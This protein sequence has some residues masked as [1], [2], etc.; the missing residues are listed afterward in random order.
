M[1]LSGL[2]IAVITVQWFTSDTLEKNPIMQKLNLMSISL[3]KTPKI[4]PRC[5]TAECT[6]FQQRLAE[7]PPGQIRAAIH[8]LVQPT[9]IKKLTT[10]LQSLDRYFNDRFHYPV[11][12]FHEEDFTSE[13]EQQV[14]NATN[15]DLYF[16]SVTFTLPDFIKTPVPEMKYS[17]G[18]RHMCRFQS[19]LVYEQPIVDNL[20]FEWRLDDD[21]VLISEIK[22]DIFKFMAVHDIIYGYLTRARDPHK[23]VTNLWRNA[24]FYIEKQNITTEF[25]NKWPDSSG[26]VNN[27]ELSAMKLWRSKRYQEYINYIDRA[28]GIYYHR[29]GDSPIK[30]I[31]VAMFV[32]L[33]KTH[34]FT[35]FVY[36]HKGKKYGSNQTQTSVPHSCLGLRGL[37]A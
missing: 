35:D 14:R 27:F 32:P 2:L 23:Y 5:D 18:Y 15:S 16:Q 7:M 10:S 21:S 6:R 36:D 11:I 37:D 25:F 31:A 12:I 8:A 26:F 20:D 22:Y 1:C 9:R 4:Y 28:G 19:K 3:W 34:C 33:N 30:A 13:H 24:T 29:W 17:V